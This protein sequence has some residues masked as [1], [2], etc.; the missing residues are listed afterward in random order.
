MGRD[1]KIGLMSGVVL[2]FVALIWVATR[3]GQSPQ[4]RMLGPSTASSQE[5]VPP[6]MLSPTASEEGKPDPGAASGGTLPASLLRDEPAGSMAQDSDLP[7]P[8]SAGPEPVA[9]PSRPPEDAD[10]T[11]S[12]QQERITTTRFHIV[13]S[14]ETLSAISMQYYGTPNRWQKIVEANPET[15]KDPNKISPGTKLNIPD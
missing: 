14:R 4:A 15:L 12:E 6:E 8:V 2:G 11:P 1:F 10:P 9:S 3:P 13:R 5:G 7:F